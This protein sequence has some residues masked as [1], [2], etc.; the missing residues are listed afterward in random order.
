MLVCCTLPFDVV[1]CNLFSLYHDVAHC[2][3][4]FFCF[5]TQL[6][7]SPSFLAMWK[8][9]LC[10]QEEPSTESGDKE[11]SPA[12]EALHEH[13]PSQEVELDVAVSEAVL[14]CNQVASPA[15]E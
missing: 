14:E 5:I 11:T 7:C 13:P 8:I 12:L 6:R 10:S 9:G 3:C 4:Q 1:A 2:S 15:D